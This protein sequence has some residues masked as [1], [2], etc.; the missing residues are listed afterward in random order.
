MIICTILCL[1]GI[2]KDIIELVDT[3]YIAGGFVMVFEWAEGDCM[4][5]MYLATEA[6]DSKASGSWSGSGR[7]RCLL[8]IKVLAS[9]DR[10]IY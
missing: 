10:N 5:R 8:A 2:L 1:R 9:R 6:A 7:M 4:G 3:Q